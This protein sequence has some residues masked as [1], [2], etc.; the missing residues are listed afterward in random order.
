MEQLVKIQKDNIYGYVVSS[1]V[2]AEELGKQH[3]HVL[4]SLD[5][6]KSSSTAD[7]SALL[8][9]GEY[10]A[11]NGKKNR[12]YLLTKDGFTLY[13]FNIQGYN[14]FKIAYI[15]KFN[16]L[17][18]Q[19]KELQP[20]IPQDYPSALRALAESV[21]HQQALAIELREK[22]DLIDTLQPKASYY[23]LV[24]QCKDLLTTTMIAKDYGFSAHK[25]NSLLV[26][27]N[28]Q[29]KQSNRYFLYA[30]YAGKGYAGSKTYP[31]TKGGE[32][33][34]ASSLAWTQKGR[35][36]IYDWLKNKGILPCIER[37]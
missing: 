15:N 33:A 36:F 3:K 29:Y 11:S 12:E 24:L 26:E 25:L 37:N 4:E 6:L 7:I 1:R 20:L 14:D 5:N 10:I 13:M 32:P 21:E 19:V 27:D 18:K 35:L 30:K 16:E 28:I 34:T 9:S 23:D 8:I 31:I 2:I 17:E 22:S